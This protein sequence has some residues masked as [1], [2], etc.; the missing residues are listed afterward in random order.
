MNWVLIPALWLGGFLLVCIF[1]RGAKCDER[2]ARRLDEQ[3]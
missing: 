1:L 3:A 2:K